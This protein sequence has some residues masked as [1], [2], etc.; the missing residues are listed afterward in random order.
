MTIPVLGQCNCLDSFHGKTPKRVLN[1]LLG[2]YWSL[3]H[4]NTS[5]KILL[6]GENVS[7]KEE[8]LKNRPKGGM[9]VMAT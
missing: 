4:R 9:V 7:E 5:N 3:K 8:N 6:K 1:W 2:V